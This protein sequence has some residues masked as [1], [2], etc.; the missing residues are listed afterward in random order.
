MT[1][2]DAWGTTFYTLILVGLLLYAY[3]PR[4]RNGGD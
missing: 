2:E 4:K 3:W 1:R